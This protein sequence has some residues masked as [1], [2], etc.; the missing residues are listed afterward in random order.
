M[1]RIMMAALAAVLAACGGGGGGG[2]GGSGSGSGGAVVTPPVSSDG[3]SRVVQASCPFTQTLGSSRGDSLRIAAVHWLQ[4][5]QL[6]AADSESRLAG[7]KAVKLRIDLLASGS[8]LA[9]VRR[10]LRVYDPVS[11]TCTSLTV[12]GPTRVPAAADAETLDSSFVATIP[13]ELVKPGMSVSLVFDDAAGRSSSEADQVYRVLQPSVSPVVVETVRIVPLTLLGSTG[14]VS[15]NQ[16]IADLLTRMYP[17]SRVNV[18]TAAPLNITSLLLSSLVSSGGVLTGTIGLM[19]SL[20]SQA[21][22]HCADLNG[23]QRNA[24]TAPKCIV[25]I[26]DNLLF[27]AASGVGQLVGLAY[28]GGTTLLTRSVSAV[29]RTSVISPYLSSHWISYDAMTVA[30]EY[31]HLLDLDHAACGGATGLDSRLYSDGGLG[32][33][34]GYDSVRDVYFSAARKYSDGS[35][36]FADVMSYCGKEWM[37]DRGYLAAM[38]YRAGSASVAARALDS[39]ADSQWLKLSLMPDGWKVRRVSHAPATLVDSSLV[40]AVTGSH[41]PEN[42][43]LRSAVVSE[44]HEAGGFGPYYIDLGERRVETLRI[45]SS[46]IELAGW[47]GD[48]I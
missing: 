5:V 29:D 47:S 44:H 3:S 21:D 9:P 34:A 31:G 8:P 35:A 4:S 24:R 11:A 10:E 30:H 26:P 7:G 23:S 20:L 27:K 6:N 38:A 19:Q 42:L 32:S 46:G 45:L 16:E 13:A 40:L 1:K 36:Q 18:E 28:V 25:V 22:D 15:S 48:D 39:E 14:Y 2:G 43:A 37:S 41:G 12:S 17:V 33:G